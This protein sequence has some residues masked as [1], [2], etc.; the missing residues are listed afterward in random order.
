MYVYKAQRPLEHPPL[1]TTGVVAPPPL[2]SPFNGRL[3]HNLLDKRLER[4]VWLVSWLKW[5][6]LGPRMRVGLG[7]I[8]RMHLLT[9]QH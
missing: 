1:H 5:L 3:F 9:S 8:S 6:L 2:N 4:L 7:G